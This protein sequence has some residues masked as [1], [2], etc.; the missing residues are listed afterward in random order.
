MELPGAERLTAMASCDA[1]CTGTG[2]ALQI[3]YATGYSSGP[4]RFQS[5]P[6]DPGYDGEDKDRIIQEKDAE[7]MQFGAGRR[8]RDGRS[9]AGATTSV[10]TA[11]ATATVPAPCAPAKWIHWHAGAAFPHPCVRMYVHVIPHFAN[12][13]T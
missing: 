1:A 7:L 6:F 3:N 12:K 9:N 5:K 2:F 11:T 13:P 10:T 4:K 8:R